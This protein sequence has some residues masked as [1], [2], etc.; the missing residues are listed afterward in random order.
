MRPS[1]LL[2]FMLASVARGIAKLI[3]EPR[4]RGTARD[5]AV[6]HATTQNIRGSVCESCARNGNAR[7]GAAAAK[8]GVAIL[9]GDLRTMGLG[10]QT[11]RAL[12]G[13]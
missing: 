8:D 11:A 3:E 13:V 5:L 2:V 6:P 9:A 4:I 12:D 1:Y 10:R 7:S